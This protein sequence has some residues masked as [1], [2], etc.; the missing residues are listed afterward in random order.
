LG[1]STIANQAQDIFN[2][3]TGFGDFNFDTS[4]IQE[5]VNNAIN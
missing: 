5:G 4:F 2:S 1:I 3:L